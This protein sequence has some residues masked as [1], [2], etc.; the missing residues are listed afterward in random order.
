MKVSGIYKFSTSRARGYTKR[1]K[2]HLFLGAT[3]MRSRA[4][5]AFFMINTENY[6]GEGFALTS[7]EY[8]F[9]SNAKSYIGCTSLIVYPNAEINASSGM[10]FLGLLTQNDVC[11]FIG[12]VQRSEILEGRHIKFIC[13]NLR[14][15]AQ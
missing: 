5:Y 14:L 3:G 6:Y 13:D 1:T 10:D 9:F 4:D 7:A 2:Y 11:R 12:H 15:L 8:P